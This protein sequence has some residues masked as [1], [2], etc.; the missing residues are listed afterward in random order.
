MRPRLAIVLVASL[1]LSTVSLASA[2][3]LSA[4]CNAI[5]LIQPANASVNVRQTP[6][7]QITPK[8]IRTISAGTS[9]PAGERV[10]SS[11]GHD[12]YGLCA[13]G[14][15]QDSVVKVSTLTATATATKVIPTRIPSSTPKPI[16]SGTP[17]P[18]LVWMEFS[19]GTLFQ[20]ALPCHVNVYRDL[21]TRKP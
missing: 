7:V 5:V 1:F 2:Y 8:P 21:P 4:P 14:Y 11:D 17:T 20:C 19:D 15:V 16:Q 9:E 12:W 18:D 10:R 3:A 6:L 13:G